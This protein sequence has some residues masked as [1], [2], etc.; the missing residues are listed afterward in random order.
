[1]NFKNMPELNWEIGYPLALITMLAID[2]YL[3]VKFK[4]TGWL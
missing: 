4:K 3:W 2:A 1:M